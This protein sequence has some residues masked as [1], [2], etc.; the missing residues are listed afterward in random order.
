MQFLNKFKFGGCLADDMGLGKTV[1]T[2]ALLQAQKEQG[3]TGASLLVMP[4]SLVYNWEMEAKKFTPKLKTFTY[5]GTNREKDPSK[6]AKYDVIITSYGIIRL[7][8]EL[9]QHY[10]FNYVILDE[11]QAIKNPTSNIAKAVRELNARNRLILTGT[12]LENSTMD[13]WSQMNFINP[14]LLGT[15]S[16]FKNEFLNPIEKQGDQDKTKKLYSIIKPFIL[17]RHKSQV[18]TELP[19][20]TENIQ[21][22]AMLPDQEA[23]YEKVKNYYRNEILENIEQK[24]L[25]KSQMI[26]LQ[27]LTKLRQIANHPKM[28][29]EE[30]DGASGKLWDVAFMLDNA[31]TEGHKILIFSQFVKHLSI[32]GKH[33]KTMN[34]DYAYLDGSTKDRQEQV[35]RFQND[36]DLKVFLIS[37]KAGGLGLNLTKADYVFILDPWWNPAAEAQA[38]DRAHRIGQQNKVFTYKF[39]TKNTVEEKILAL[40]QHKQKLASDLIT[41]ESSFVKSLSKEDIESLLT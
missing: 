20:K 31:I 40:Q 16:F 7:D 5:T 22:S 11:S 30:Y 6:F 28:V 29:D 36:D 24:G 17:R 2:L 19:E 34:I 3:A 1:Q 21:Y 38:V 13:L 4:T 39:I 32:I 25:N 14:G 10:R 27:G 12:P 35:E 15:Q 37:L 8:I 23:E 18:A 33:L 9:L 41:T 26:L